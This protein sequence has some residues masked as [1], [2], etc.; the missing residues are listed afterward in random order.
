MSHALLSLGTLL[1]HRNPSHTMLVEYMDNYRV[2]MLTCLGDAEPASGH[3]THVWRRVDKLTLGS[4]QSKL[5][6]WPWHMLIRYWQELGSS[7]VKL[8]HRHSRSGILNYACTVL[9]S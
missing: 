3:S 2:Q 5:S 6:F 1:F 4:V 9:K 7:F 8:R